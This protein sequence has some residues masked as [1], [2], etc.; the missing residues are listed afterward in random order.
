MSAS[1][2][3]RIELA[4]LSAQ[5]SDSLLRGLVG[6]DPAL[7]EVCALVTARAAGTP[8]F[9]E[10]MVQ[11]LVEQG[12]LARERNGMRL[13]RE[14]DEIRIPATVQSLLTARV[15][16]LPA[17]A[18][19]ALQI[20]AV[21]GKRFDEPLLRAVLGDDAPAL[22][23]SLRTL[24]RAD[25]IHPDGASHFAFKHPL[26]QEVAY[27]SQLQEIRAARHEAVA[28]A[29][30]ALHQDRLGEHADLLAHHR[31]AAGKR[32]Q[33]HRWRRLAALRG[34]NIQLRRPGPARP[35]RWTPTA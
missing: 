24:Q 10:E 25:L 34:T 26:T 28:R 22:P 16:S 8:L 20:A 33:A 21:A 1:Y 9:A 2:F 14:V 3:E 13:V 12:A 27:G 19:R 23:E 15:D 35:K 31:D 4:P 5:A 11:A 29:L 18:K 6:A 7:A 17:G 30:Q 32:A